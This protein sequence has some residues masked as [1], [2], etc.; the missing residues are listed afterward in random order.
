MPGLEGFPIPEPKHLPREA[1]RLTVRFQ[2]VISSIGEVFDVTPENLDSKREQL[3]V[4]HRDAWNFYAD[5]QNWIKL[6]QEKRPEEKSSDLS[7]IRRLAEIAENMA[8]GVDSIRQYTEKLIALR[9]KED[10]NLERKFS[11][12]A[13]SITKSEIQRLRIELGQ[14]AGEITLSTKNTHREKLKAFAKR[15]SRIAALTLAMLAVDLKTSPLHFREK[16]PEKT[17]TERKINPEDAL[18]N[19][20][21]DEDEYKPDMGGEGDPGK[22]ERSAEPLAKIDFSWLN[23]IDD[24]LWVQKIIRKREDGKLITAEAP[25]INK[26]YSYEHAR[27]EIKLKNPRSG[28]RIKLPVPQGFEF[29]NVET[30]PNVSIGYGS[31]E[32]GRYVAF[33]G[34][35]KEKLPEIT[36]SYSVYRVESGL[37]D[38]SLERTSPISRTEEDQKLIEDLR[39]A[40]PEQFERALDRHLSDFT[41][42]VSSEI[43]EIFRSLPGTTEEKVG[44]L[45]IGDC[46]MLSAYAMGLLNDA[47][48][49]AWMAVGL[50]E[51]RDELDALRRH[52]KLLYET[53]DGRELY[54]TTSPTKYALV[55]LV[56]LPKDK[57]RLENLAKE[58][59]STVNGE[60]LIPELGRMRQALEEILKKPEYKKYRASPDSITPDLKDIQK[61]IED[62]LSGK[63]EKLLA[64]PGPESALGEISLILSIIF[65]FVLAML[66]GLYSLSKGVG[67]LDEGLRKKAKKS[68]EENIRGVAELFTRLDS[69]YE[70]QPEVPED[71]RK[72]F[73][74]TLENIYRWHPEL[75][76]IIPLDKVRRYN[77]EQQKTWLKIAGLREVYAKDHWGVYS[78]IREIFRS[79]R[80]NRMKKRLQADH[81]EVLPSLE[82]LEEKVK[83]LMANP[84]LREKL[85]EKIPEGVEEIILIAENMLRANPVLAHDR[86][87]LPLVLKALSIERSKLS[88][89]KISKR[90]NMDNTEFESYVPYLPGM[91]TR[92]IDWRVYGR[93]DKLVV[94][95]PEKEGSRDTPSMI[96][97]VAVE[98]TN[99]GEETLASLASLLIYAQKSPGQFYIKTVTLMANGEI[100]GRFDAKAA[101]NFTTQPDK[102]PIEYLMSKILE[103]KLEHGFDIEDIGPD[104]YQRNHILRK[105]SGVLFPENIDRRRE[106]LLTVGFYEGEIENDVPVSTYFFEKPERGEEVA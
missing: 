73:A 3:F 92:R 7:F 88:D 42:V 60:N 28:D 30:E 93:N 55:N 39:K 11:E 37:I 17:K 49:K 105:L 26:M 6:F 53:K 19:S 25:Q 5:L 2:E 22:F 10:R 83:Y 12:E 38:F 63:W 66:G 96:L 101:S 8:S 21:M 47:N 29:N 50:L 14:M 23:G 46:D 34:N 18:S 40:K 82:E 95:K 62:V 16:N 59:S 74:E 44:T 99:S 70:S 104:R 56:L 98:V 4:L 1:K 35:E 32:N 48:H 84:Q 76:D 52:A 100:A 27:V 79:A 61:M 102:K 97:H 80:W 81:A 67:K 78:S 72:F 68:Q 64:W 103:L 106:S 75:E 85:A 69:A 15:A 58:I 65:G 77:Q 20:H 90:G 94:R 54:E 43:D 86:A 33:T 87:P 31:N 36:L 91:D 51:Q 9:D 71:Q 89:E 45:K 24:P 13:V 41:Y 57:A